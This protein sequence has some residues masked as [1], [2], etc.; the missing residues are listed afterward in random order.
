M[1]QSVDM[2]ALRFENDRTYR[3]K[4][5]VQNAFM[6]DDFGFTHFHTIFQ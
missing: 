5:E 6:Y 1:Y 4:P 3:F 2:D